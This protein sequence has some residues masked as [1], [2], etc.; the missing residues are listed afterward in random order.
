MIPGLG[1]R[2]ARPVAVALAVLLAG[3]QPA[4]GQTADGAKKR[5]GVLTEGKEC[6][7]SQDILSRNL[8]AP[9]AARGFVEGRNLEFVIRCVPLDQSRIEEYA[10]QLAAER[11]DVLMTWGTTK[12]RALQRASSTI[13]ILAAVGDPVGS[14]FARSLANPGGNITGLSYGVSERAQKNL[15]LLREV[16]PG[17]AQLI[18]LYGKSYGSGS[19]VTAPFV[20]AAKA[21]GISTQL[22]LVGSADDVARALRSVATP[23]RSAALA[24][25]IFEVDGR[26]LA[27]SALRHGIALMPLGE[28]VVEAG[29]LISLQLTYANEAERTAMLLEKLLRGTPPAQIPF[30]LPTRSRLAVNKRTAAAL[31]LPLPPSLLLR[32]DKVYE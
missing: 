18:I 27:E 30:E 6:E 3:A 8:A 17:L 19:E 1:V 29:G 23:R 22:H 4:S 2:I 11:V 13:P 21:A 7:K 14:G 9:L 12:T 32:A 10:R 5:V 31:K 20:A 24:F 26:T 15:E 28:D 25:N 16:V